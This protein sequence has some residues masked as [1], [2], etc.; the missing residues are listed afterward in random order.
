MNSLIKY[1]VNK[2]GFSQKRIIGEDSSVQTVDS[3]KELVCSEIF[4]PIQEY[5][6]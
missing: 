6:E 3:K 2:A 5:G 1:E 4:N